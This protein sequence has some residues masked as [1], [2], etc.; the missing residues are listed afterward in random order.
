MHATG[1]GGKQIAILG[2]ETYGKHCLARSRR[3]HD[4]DTGRGA[5]RKRCTLQHDAEDMMTT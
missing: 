1:W 5:K 4:Q 3:T 2:Q